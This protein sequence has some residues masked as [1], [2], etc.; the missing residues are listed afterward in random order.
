MDPVLWG[1]GDWDGWWGAAP[2]GSKSP[3]GMLCTPCIWSWTTGLRDPNKRSPFLHLLPRPVSSVTAQ[4]RSWPLLGGKQKEKRR[5]SKKKKERKER[6]DSGEDSKGPVQ[7][8]KFLKREE[9]N[10]VRYSVISGKKIK[11]KVEKS[12]EDKVAE[13]NRNELL[14]FLNASYE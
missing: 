5:K 14:R 13:A 1:I 3:M 8:S 7:L 10:R 9:E 6:D 12:K 4:I 2:D 11:M